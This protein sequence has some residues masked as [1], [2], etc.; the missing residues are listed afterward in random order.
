MSKS[1]IVIGAGVV[2]LACGKELSERGYEVFIAEQ[3]QYIATQTSARNSGV[4]HAGIYYPAESLKAKLCIRG[5]QLLYEYC[6]QFGVPYSRTKKMIVATT[7]EE[8]QILLKLKDTAKKN[9]VELEF[10]N[11]P[12]A[13]GKEPD[14]FAVSALVSPTTGIVDAAKLAE[15][16]QHQAEFNGANLAFE[17]KITKIS[18]G[19]KVFVSG[20]S[21]GEEFDTE[22]DFLI[23]A[24]GHGAHKLTQSYWPKAPSLPKNFAKGNYFSIAGKAPFQTLIYPVPGTESLGIHYTI[25][26]DGRGQLGPNVQWVN[27]PTYEVDK[28]LEAEF[29]NAVRTYWPGVE[30]RELI[31]GYSGIRPRVEAKDFVIHSKG[32]IITLL[33]I[34]S[35]GLTSSLAIAEL[36]AEN[37]K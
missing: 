36:V 1:V 16:F 10:I 25:D 12:D 31:P 21:S 28:N 19:S 23:N 22:F 27:Q 34:E 33:G 29:R 37:L 9:G 30:D 18:Q 14:L 35:P 20:V 17:T 7:S 8:T 5:K 11:G 2:G 4:I 6:E 15:S 26:T 13:I 3:E 24:A 32:N